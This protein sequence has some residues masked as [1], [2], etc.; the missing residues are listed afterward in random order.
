MKPLKFLLLIATR[1]VVVI[2]AIIYNMDMMR[3]IKLLVAIEA[4]IHNMDLMKDITLGDKKPPTL[5]I[6]LYV[7]NQ[8]TSH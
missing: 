2:E 3:D 4:I 1:S 5:K 6:M 8:P 7:K